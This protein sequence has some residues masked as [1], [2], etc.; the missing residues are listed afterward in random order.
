MSHC[1][2][3]AD[4]VSRKGA[5][6]QRTENRPQL[7]VF[8]GA[9]A[10]AREVLW[11]CAGGALLWCPALVA[12]QEP[13]LAGRPLQFSNIV[14][15]YRIGVSA[16][17]VTIPVEEPITLRVVITGQGPAKY[18]PSR[19]F[20]KLFP[21]RWAQDFYIETVPDEDRADPGQNSW[22][23]V[24]R[25]RPKHE[26]VAAIDGIKLVYYE[27]GQNGGGKFQTDNAEPVAIKV[28]PRRAAPP[29]P[30]GVPTR[31]APASFY[32][33]PDAAAM[34]TTWPEASPAPL[35]L[36]IMLLLVPPLMTLA[37]MRGWRRLF[38]DA[39]DHRRR[40]RSRAAQRAL[41][42]LAA[43]D[44]EAAWLVFSRYLHERLDFPAEE[45]TPS[46]VKRFL[47]RRGASRPIAEKLA[48]F[49][50]TCDA[51]RFAGTLTNGA[52]PLRDE[53]SHLIH[54][55]EDDLCTP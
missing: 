50:A 54:A 31:T 13:P 36:L 8:R 52:G 44:G 22:Q 21:E 4:A 39:H 43:A 24:Y 33:L 6:A 29:I 18:Q 12:G 2:N 15:K 41:Q 51:A 11:L 35:W 55:L 28:K 5:E 48:A 10:S 40:E 38:P 42:A 34:L 7:R 26:R 47:R 37:C 46:E 1:G 17:P 14:G 27:P 20:L 23:F 16:E 30:D 19:R 49:L 9:I 25:L 45:P 3:L 32:E 53:V